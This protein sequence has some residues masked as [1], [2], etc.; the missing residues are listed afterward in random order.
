[1]IDIILT[2]VKVWLGAFALL[3]IIVFLLHVANKFDD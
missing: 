2:G 1:M 3:A